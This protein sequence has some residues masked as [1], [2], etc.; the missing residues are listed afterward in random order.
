MRQLA[1]GMLAALCL[2]APVGA[3]SQT[4]GD[5]TGGTFETT[6]WGCPDLPMILPLGQVSP[7]FG[8]LGTGT[9]NATAGRIQCVKVFPVCHKLASTVSNRVGT[10]LVGGEFA[11]G[12]YDMNGN[13]VYNSGIL[14][15]TT[16]GVKTGATAPFQLVARTLYHFCWASS[17][18]GAT[19]RFTGQT[20]DSGYTGTSQRLVPAAPVSL[21]AQFNVNC[22]GAANPYPCCT[23]A[24]AGTC[25]GMPAVI[26]GL[27]AGAV[28]TYI[29]AFTN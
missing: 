8:T 16:T 4:F 21:L 19:I 20:G 5:E 9:G 3:G 22:A 17:D 10:L 2:L 25:T 27:T 7:L 24:G 6:T 23:G 18:A 12:I 13:I 11:T 29:V 1:A 28:N 15:S 26:S 14:S